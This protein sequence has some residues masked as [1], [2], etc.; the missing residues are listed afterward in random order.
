[1]GA[2][3]GV[4]SEYGRTASQETLVRNDL[5]AMP[6]NTNDGTARG[7]FGK[8]VLPMAT[9]GSV[10]E[11]SVQA[12]QYVSAVAGVGIEKLDTFRR[13]CGVTVSDERG[14]LYLLHCFHMPPPE[15]TP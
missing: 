9:R 1:M 11:A 13:Q 4:V 10:A 15:P 2:D 6:G 7:V 5:V 14:M 8:Q 3:P 12:L